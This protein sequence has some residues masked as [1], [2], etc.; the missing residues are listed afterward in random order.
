ML[1]GQKLHGRASH[2]AFAVAVLDKP[3][4]A[5][6]DSKG[7]PA[8]TLTAADGLMEHKEYFRADEK[9]FLRMGEIKV[10]RRG[11]GQSEV[12][13]GRREALRSA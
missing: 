1:D 3:L 6:L 7:L 9:K 10:R 8:I 12:L 13:A 4:L 2:V 11:L 5:L